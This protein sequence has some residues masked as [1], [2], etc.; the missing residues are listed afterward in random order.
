MSASSQTAPA[1][2]FPNLA[3]SVLVISGVTRACACVPRARRIRSTPAVMLPHWSLPPHLEKAAV[4]VEQG[5]VVVGL[6]QHVAELG[7]RD[8]TG[9]PALDRLLGEHVVDAEVLADVPHEVDGAYL[10]EPVRV[11]D[12]EGRVVLRVEVQE[13]RELRSDALQVRLKAL[14][15]EQRTLLRTCRPG[16]R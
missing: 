14:A 13:P 3:P 8:P 4:A 5:H 15:R 1:S 11:I 12:Q 16:H 6:Q 10:F 9:Q 2:V 7:V